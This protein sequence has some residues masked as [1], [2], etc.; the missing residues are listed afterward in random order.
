M[1]AAERETRDLLRGASALA[2]KH[3]KQFAAGTPPPSPSDQPDVLIGWRL[4][5][6]GFTTAPVWL[7]REWLNRVMR[8]L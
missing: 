1:N 5:G 3:V 7:K 4:F 2:W 6:R 8:Q